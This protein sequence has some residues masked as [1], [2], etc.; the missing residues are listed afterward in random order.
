MICRFYSIF[1]GLNPNVLMKKLLVICSIA[2]AFRASA[3]VSIGA[4]GISLIAGT[5]LSA[6]GLVLVP[7][8]NL[9]LTNNTIQKSTT[10]VN[11][12]GSVFSIANVVYFSAPLSFTGTTRLNYQESELNGNAES[13]LLM[14]YQ[15]SAIWATS[16]T[17]SVNTSDNYVTETVS[18]KNFDGVTASVVYVSLPVSLTSFTAKREANASVLL[19]W[20]T[21]SEQQNSHFGIERSGDGVHYQVIGIVQASGNEFGS[22]Y[23]FTDNEPLNVTNYYRLKQYDL[24]GHETL[25][26]VRI[27]QPGNVTMALALY[28]NPVTNNFRLV[29]SVAPANPL[30]Y[31][32]Q[33]VSGQILQNGIIFTREQWLSAG[34]LAAG[35]YVLNLE[36]G[37]SVRFF[38][39]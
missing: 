37:Q 38:K 15:S 31:T 29:L 6:E 22:T 9:S 11:I 32:I 5:T 2:F 36:N 16:S 20:K 12:G 26:G 8:S 18:S 24:D 3:Q 19:Q 25:Y 28:P 1:C 7:Q 27:V 30:H 10:P 39:K 13:Q 4:D 34:A 23:T 35:V 33:N 21:A 14:V 17:S